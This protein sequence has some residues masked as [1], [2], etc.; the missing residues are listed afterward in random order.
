MTCY[1]L[2]GSK[3]RARSLASIRRDRRQEAARQGI[4]IADRSAV[5]TWE[6]QRLSGLCKSLG[7]TYDG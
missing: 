2:N 4:D 6:H 7:V 1:G 5:R 3:R